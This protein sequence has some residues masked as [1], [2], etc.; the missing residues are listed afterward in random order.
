[1]SFDTYITTKGPVVD[2]E[3]TA[4]G[5]EKA[6]EIYSWSFGASNPTVISPG[7]GGLSAG[8]VSVSSFNM[9]KKT[10]KSSAKLFQMCCKGEHFEEIKVTNR[11]A[12]GAGG[13]DGFLTYTFTNCMVESIQWSGSSGGDD[14]PTESVSVAAQKV[15]IEYKVQ[16]KDGK[17]ATGGQAAWD[18]TQ[19][20]D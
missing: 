1:M 5:F 13:Q 2:G 3:S 6:I 16:G 18:Q 17:L 4:K 20:S 10:D 8:R 12:T 9:M 7:K 15:E 19:V 11:K 14:T